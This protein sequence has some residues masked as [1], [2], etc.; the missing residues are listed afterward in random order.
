MS[1]ISLNKYMR[2]CEKRLS[3]VL[4]PQDLLYL[5]LL[6]QV[7]VCFSTAKFYQQNFQVSQEVLSS[8]IITV[9]A[10]ELTCFFFSGVLHLL[11]LVRHLTK[12]QCFPNT[13]IKHCFASRYSQVVIPVIDKTTLL[14]F[15]RCLRY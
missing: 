2:D 7:S 13:L 12:D 5:L 6:K 10:E 15:K 1:T 4:F 9:K 11:K 14:P 3:G 8:Q